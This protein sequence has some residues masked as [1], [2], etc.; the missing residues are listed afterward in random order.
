MVLSNPGNGTLGDA[1]GVVTI[2][3]DDTPISGPTVSITG[4]SALEGD[5]V[6]FVVSLS[7]PSTDVIRVDFGTVD[8]TAVGDVDYQARAIGRVTFQPGVTSAIR[9]ITTIDDNSA[10]ADE[11][12]TMQLSNPVNVTIST[13][14]AVGTII[15][16][17]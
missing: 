8:G 15:D 4:G 10:E 5:R 2:I 3:D 14:S 12:F 13:S 7:E 6:E 9:R 17:D 16:N 11:T 1:S